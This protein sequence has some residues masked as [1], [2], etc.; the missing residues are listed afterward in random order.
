MAL[1]I[2]EN[3]SDKPKDIQLKSFDFQPIKQK[4]LLKRDISVLMCKCGKQ[5][6]SNEKHIGCENSEC[7]MK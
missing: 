7:Q 3:S 6:L 2:N 4:S 1:E 5:Y